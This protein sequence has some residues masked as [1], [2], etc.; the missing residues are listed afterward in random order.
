[1]SLVKYVP[2]Y[3][4]T[5]AG[6][7]LV[8]FVTICDAK[9]DLTLLCSSCEVRWSPRMTQCAGIC[10]YSPRERF[11]TIGRYRTQKNPEKF[12]FQTVLDS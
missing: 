4:D 1:M 11:C 12:I 9:S 8:V 5:D 7:D 2:V 6:L 10:R 3:S